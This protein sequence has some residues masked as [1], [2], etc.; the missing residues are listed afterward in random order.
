MWNEKHKK[1][2]RE[3]T[4]IDRDLT[5]L[6]GILVR[7]TNAKVILSSGWRF[8]FSKKMT[9]ISIEAER[10]IEIFSAENIVIYD[11]TPDLTTKDIR[12]TK[13]FSLVKAQ[14]IL[15]WIELHEE[16]NKWIVIDDLDLHNSIVFDHQIKTN[17]EIGLTKK[18]IELAI[19]MIND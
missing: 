16:V 8:W 5:A 9:P 2:I 18:D 10:L 13:K 14:E 19:K 3:G 12:K 17:P 6:L 4:L 11:F 7:V 15:R 1:E